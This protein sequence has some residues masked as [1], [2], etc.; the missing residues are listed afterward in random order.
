M[1]CG[2][3][4]WT[5]SVSQYIVQYSLIWFLLVMAELFLPKG[6]LEIKVGNFPERQNKYPKLDISYKI[7]L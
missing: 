5:K 6:G 7:P 3:A 1:A 4:I 2:A